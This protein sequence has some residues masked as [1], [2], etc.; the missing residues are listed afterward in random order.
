MPELDE[1]LT[2][3]QQWVQKAE[4]DLKNA[5]YSLRMGADCPTDTV[6]L[7]DAKSL[8]EELG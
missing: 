8:L 4:N 2:V 6:D 7:Q 3:V 5:S 1:I